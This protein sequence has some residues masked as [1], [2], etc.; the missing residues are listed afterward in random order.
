MVSAEPTD[1]N[2]GEA[3]SLPRAAICRPYNSQLSTINEKSR[4][5]GGFLYVFVFDHGLGVFPE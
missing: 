2:V 1:W 3:I 4:P 5:V